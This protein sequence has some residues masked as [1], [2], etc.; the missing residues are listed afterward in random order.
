MTTTTLPSSD[1]MTVDADDAATVS[2]HVDDVEAT[3]S[4]KATP[5]SAPK[6]PHSNKTTWITLAIIVLTSFLAGGLVTLL[7][8]LPERGGSSP[9][10]NEQDPTTTEEDAN[11]NIDKD[12]T[13]VDVVVVEDTN[14]PPF[15]K[16][17]QYEFDDHDL[18]DQCLVDPKDAHCIIS[19]RM[20]ALGTTQSY[21][22]GE[23]YCK[24]EVLQDGYALEMKLF[25]TVLQQDKL[26]L[27]GFTYSGTGLRFDGYPVDMGDKLTWDSDN[28]P[29]LRDPLKIRAGWHICLVPSNE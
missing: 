6:Q 11:N 29:D 15:W 24:F 10:L 18:D 19:H 9:S 21:S 25:D 13:D 8:V 4:T 20:A 23:V 1:P 28:G 16:V 2:T 3:L 17:Y 12:T 22:D 14:S 26:S 5:R 27:H 7:V